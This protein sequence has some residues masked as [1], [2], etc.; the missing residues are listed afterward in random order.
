MFGLTQPK[1][2]AAGMYSHP[3]NPAS[4]DV[5]L[6]LLLLLGVTGLSI[7]Y[8]DGER[9]LEHGEQPGGQI[10]KLLGGSVLLFQ[11]EPSLLRTAPTQSLLQV[12]G[13]DCGEWSAG[14]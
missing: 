11:S 4:L 10:W 9:R 8:A 7:K 12:Q 1:A 5:T 14:G 3:L 13:P 2:T 6:L